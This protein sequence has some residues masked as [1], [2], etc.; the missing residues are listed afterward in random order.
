MTTDKSS[1]CIIRLG[2]DYNWW[3]HESSDDVHCDTEYAG[4]LDPKQLERVSDLLSALRPYGL[5][6]EVVN[7]ALVLFSIDKE[8][9]KE[10]L[11]VTETKDNIFNPRESIFGLPNVLGEQ[12]GPFIEFLDHIIALRIKLLN[13]SLDFQQPLNIEEIEDILHAEQQ[14]R[15]I[16]GIKMHVF[17][18]IMSILDYVP[19][20]YS[21]DDEDGDEIKDEQE[22]DLSDF[23]DD[24]DESIEIDEETNW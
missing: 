19:T 1:W 12:E 5:K 6:D 10:M 8:M 14:E 11:R 23:D 9:P 3:V 16:S 22:L 7:N 4:I 2:E 18:E 20:G 24:V 15:Y 21:L 17:D 13:A